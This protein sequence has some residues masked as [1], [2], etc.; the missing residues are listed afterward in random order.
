MSG[1]CFIIHEFSIQETGNLGVIGGQIVP[2]F[3]DAC[4]K[5]FLCWSPRLKLAM[6]SCDLQTPTEMLGKVYAV[7]NRRR[8]KILSEDV[9]QLRIGY[10]TIKSMIP[11]I[12]SFGFSDEIRKKTSGNASPQLVFCG[13]E[14]LDQD[15]F[16]VPWTLEE[17]EDIGEK[18]DKENVAL[19]Y[20]NKVRRR[21]GMHVTE[22]IVEHAEKQTT[23]KSQ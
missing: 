13:Y 14:L 3:V 6:Y 16:W 9:E 1:V 22:K 17:L 11:V 23:L 15:P 20:M 21:K 19:K 2:T 10:F 7:L 12:E 5:A 4:K 18:A 8:G